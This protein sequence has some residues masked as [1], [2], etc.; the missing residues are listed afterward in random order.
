MESGGGRCK[1][2]D[3][4]IH[5]GK[6]KLPPSE[7]GRPQSCLKPVSQEIF[8]LE[9]LTVAGHFKH[10][11]WVAPH[12]HFNLTYLIEAEEGRTLCHKE[13]ENSSVR[14]FSLEEALKA[15]TEPWMVEH[16][17]GRLIEKMKG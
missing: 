3:A 16:V 2:T 11:E 10:G 8:S 13:D 1:G 12:L 4:P 14:W 7:C 9:T 5:E 15:S 6:S 17:Y